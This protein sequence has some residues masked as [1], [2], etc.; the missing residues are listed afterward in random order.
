MFQRLHRLHSTGA[1]TVIHASRCWPVHPIVFRRRPDRI[2]PPRVGKQNLELWLDSG[3][4][5]DCESIQLEEDKITTTT[6][7]GK[8]QVGPIDF[9]N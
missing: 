8:D 7:V 1:Q 2:H 6:E 5:L 3:Q 4:E 9:R